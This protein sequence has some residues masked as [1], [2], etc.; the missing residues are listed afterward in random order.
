M[1][2]TLCSNF[3]KLRWIWKQE[4]FRSIGREKC[5]SKSEVQHSRTV[6]LMPQAIFP[7]LFCS[8][9]GERSGQVKLSLRHSDYHY[10]YMRLIFLLTAGALPKYPFLGNPAGKF[11]TLR[12][13]MCSRSICLWGVIS[14]ECH[15]GRKLDWRE[16]RLIVRIRPNAANGSG[17]VRRIR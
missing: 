11:R 2:P 15:S 6:G 5:F 3:L 10:D 4:R 8:G 7:H 14:M 17:Y 12:S 9:V 13:K 1:S 16:A